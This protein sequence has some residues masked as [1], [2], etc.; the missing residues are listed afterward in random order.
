MPMR[1]QGLNLPHFVRVRS[2]I[3]PMIGSLSASKI[4][5]PTMIAVMAESWAAVSERVKSTKVS[6]KLVTRA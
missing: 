6:R 3:L 1:I 2:M 4:R 5:A